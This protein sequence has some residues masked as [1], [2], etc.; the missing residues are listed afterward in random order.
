MHYIAVLEELDKLS[1]NFVSALQLAEYLK[2]R[3]AEFEKVNVL[4]YLTELGFTQSHYNEFVFNIVWVANQLEIEVRLT[5]YKTIKYVQIKDHN[6]D[7]FTFYPKSIEELK[8]L[9]SMLYEK[10]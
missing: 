7:Y 9:I 4:D 3:N 8:L 10:Q 5:D 1:E 6:D 2:E